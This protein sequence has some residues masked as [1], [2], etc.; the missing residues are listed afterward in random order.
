MAQKE[1]KREEMKQNQGRTEQNQRK[2]VQKKTGYRAVLAASMF[3]IAASAALSACK[4]S[5]AAE[6]TAQTQ[7]AE[8]TEGAVSTALGA[9]DRVL[10][11]NGMLY[12]KYRTEI[13]SL[14]KE[15][16]EM[17]TLCQFDTGDENS[18]FWVYG[19]GL[20]F[21]RIQAESGST[22]GTELYGLY[23][24]DLESGVEEHLADLTDQPS[25]LYASK[26][27]LYVKGYNM[28]VIYTLD[29]NG[30]TAGE[31]SPSDTI[32]GEIP[33]GC[34]ELFNGILPYYTEQFG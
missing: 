12:L 34:S 27:R 24:L 7:A 31:L 11:E 10:E 5:P 17:K 22:Q 32:Y 9:A 13:R 14:S 3:L 20:Y 33:A 29:E 30:K 4:K 26:N 19:G 15:T 1:W 25:V 18:T 8:E 6:T 21:D 16:G 2:K 23:R 28:N